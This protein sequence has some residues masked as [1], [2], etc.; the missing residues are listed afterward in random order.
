MRAIVIDIVVVASGRVCATSTSRWRRSPPPP[1][2]TAI[3]ISIRATT[4]PRPSRRPR[5]W[6]RTRRRRR[7]SGRDGTSARRAHRRRRRRRRRHPRRLSVRS[8]SPPT[9]YRK[10]YR[11]RGATRVA[12]RTCITTVSICSTS[13]TRRNSRGWACR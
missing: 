5:G 6:R 3:A 4:G 2:T 13:G 10:S 9:W 8:R 7:R 1:T 12:R 11:C